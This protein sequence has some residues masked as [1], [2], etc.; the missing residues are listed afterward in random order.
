MSILEL[1]GARY[2]LAE[3]RKQLN[4]MMEKARRAADVECAA[5]KDFS[6]FDAVFHAKVAAVQRGEI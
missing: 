2:E 4:A 3:Y 5:K 1:Q 6:D